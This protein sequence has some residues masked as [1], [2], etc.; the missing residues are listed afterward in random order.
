M[1]RQIARGLTPEQAACELLTH[2]CGSKKKPTETST[3]LL[4]DK[5]SHVDAKFE[6]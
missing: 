6:L 3:L 2:Y 5:N 4:A 1:R